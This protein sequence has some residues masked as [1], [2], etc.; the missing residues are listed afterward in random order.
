MMVTLENPITEGESEIMFPGF[1]IN[2]VVPKSKELHLSICNILSSESWKGGYDHSIVDNMSMEREIKI[3]MHKKM[4]SQETMV[5]NVIQESG[6]GSLVPRARRVF[7]EIRACFKKSLKKDP[8][9]ACRVFRDFPKYINSQGVGHFIV[10]G[11]RS[12]TTEPRP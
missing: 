4:L 6:M 1:I 3:I 2:E 10:V 9:L 8:L 7:S 11:L 12:T 5:I